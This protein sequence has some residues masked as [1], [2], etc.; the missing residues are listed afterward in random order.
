MFIDALRGLAALGVACY[1]IHR[2][3]PLHEPASQLI[4]APLATVFEHGWMGVQVFF[5]ISGFVIAYSVHG[6]PISP[7]FLGNFALRRSIRLDPP[8]WTTI[9]FVLGLYGLARILGLGEDLIDPP[10]WGQFFA[11]AFY[12]QD[13]AGYGNISVGFWSLCVEV[14]FYLALIVMLG[15]AQWL[16]RRLGR[17]ADGWRGLP[18]GRDRPAGLGL[19]GRV[20]RRQRV[21]CVAGALLLHVLSRRSRMV[22]ARRPRAAAPSSGDMSHCC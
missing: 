19:A 12:V 21:G 3:G 13:I 11:H 15:A 5:V 16:H 22:D 6:V 2:Y 17:T 18:A 7:K 10:S 9:F 8:Y 1:H 20:Q 4:P 14:Q